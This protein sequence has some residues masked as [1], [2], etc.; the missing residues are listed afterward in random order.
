MESASTKVIRKSETI[1]VKVM[2]NVNGKWTGAEG[3]YG[4]LVVTSTK[5][6]TVESNGEIIFNATL[7]GVE[8]NEGER[9]KHYFRIGANADGFENQVFLI[10]VQNE[11]EVEGVFKRLQDLV[12]NQNGN[13]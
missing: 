5:H 2:R 6:L 10:K 7:E 11:R 3:P 13:I 1:W 8:R 4:T 12:S 9:K